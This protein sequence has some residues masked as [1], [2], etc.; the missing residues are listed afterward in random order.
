MSDDDL[1]S[2]FKNNTGN[3][4]GRLTEQQLQADHLI[5]GKRIPWL[6]YFFQVAIPAFLFSAKTNAQGSV[7]VVVKHVV[8]KKKVNSLLPASRVRFNCYSNL[9]P[10][11]LSVSPKPPRQGINVMVGAISVVS[12]KKIPP[13]KLFY[14]KLKYSTTSPL[15]PAI[16]KNNS[17]GFSIFPNPVNSHSDLNIKWDKS[18]YSNQSVEIFDQSGNLVQQEML[19]LKQ[20]T[21]RHSIILKQLASGIY[22]IKITD[23]KTRTISSKQFIVQ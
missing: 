9:I 8:E 6:K 7:K 23:S 21:S 17:G 22:V 3:V 20:K 4:C 13:H 11:N 12:A 2:F 14:A 15:L 10:D 19:A 18:I 5:P 16:I 1:V